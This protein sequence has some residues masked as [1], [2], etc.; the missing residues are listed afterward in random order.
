MRKLPFG[1]RMGFKY[2]TIGIDK[3]GAHFKPKVYDRVLFRLNKGI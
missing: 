3:K 2:D 1:L